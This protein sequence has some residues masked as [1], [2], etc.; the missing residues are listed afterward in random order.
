MIIYNKSLDAFINTF[1]ILYF[2]LRNGVAIALDETMEH[3]RTERC[4]TFNN[5]PLSPDL[6]FTCKIIEVFGLQ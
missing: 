6:D 3:C 4:D 5:P 2:T 1:K